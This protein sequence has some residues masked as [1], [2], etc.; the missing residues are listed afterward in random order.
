M[1]KTDKVEETMVDLP[2]VYNT[3]TGFEV[4][5]EYLIQTYHEEDYI[6]KKRVG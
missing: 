1:G 3:S 5:D 2:S 6:D 4:L